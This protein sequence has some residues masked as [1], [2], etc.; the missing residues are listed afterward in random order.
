MGHSAILGL[1]A[2]HGNSWDLAGMFLHNSVVRQLCSKT[3]HQ[4]SLNEEGMETFKKQTEGIF[5]RN[6]AS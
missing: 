4:Y 6:D 2:E 5:P 1:A 3:T